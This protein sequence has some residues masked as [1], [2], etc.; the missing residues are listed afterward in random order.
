MSPESSSFSQEIS[1]ENSGKVLDATSY[2]CCNFEHKMW[3]GGGR[4]PTSSSCPRRTEVGQIMSRGPGDEDSSRWLHNPRTTYLMSAHI[5]VLSLPCLTIWLFLLLHIPHFYWSKCIYFIT[6]NPAYSKFLSTSTLKVFLV[7]LSYHWFF[8]PPLVL[9][10]YLKITAL[11]GSRCG[12]HSSQWSELIPHRGHL[13]LLQCLVLQ[14]THTFPS[15]FE[16]EK[17]RVI[18]IIL[19]CWFL[20][21]TNPWLLFKNHFLGWLRLFTE[22]HMLTVGNF[23]KPREQMI[24]IMINM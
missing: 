3:K 21:N 7:L 11:E 4:R 20:P 13:T 22:Q 23:K 5:F 6:F 2:D 16:T 8:F 17:F 14:Q 9:Y 1:Q 24:N 15:D 10:D 19:S 18:L 12:L